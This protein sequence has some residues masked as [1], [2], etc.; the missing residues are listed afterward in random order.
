MYLVESTFPECDLI[1]REFGYNRSLQCEFRT[2]GGKPKKNCRGNYVLNTVCRGNTLRAS[3]KKTSTPNIVRK[4]ELLFPNWRERKNRKGKKVMLGWTT[5]QRS[6]L[7]VLLC[8]RWSEENIWCEWD[9]DDWPEE[10]LCT[11]FEFLFL[12][13]MK[14]LTFILIIGHL[15]F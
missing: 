6:T 11:F 1:R 12:I 8:I 2:S 14:C 13:S 15:E 10:I 5:G 9:I 3:S 7:L 4:W